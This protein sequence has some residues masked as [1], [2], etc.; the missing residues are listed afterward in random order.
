M[1]LEQIIDGCKR[2]DNNA[3]RELY[4]R[5]ANLIFGLLCRYT[6]N[7]SSAEDLL[8]DTFITIFTHIEDYRNEGAFDGWCRRIAIRTAIDHLRRE[9]R[10]DLLEID[11]LQ[12]SDAITATEPNVLDGISN[13]ELMRTINEL[14]PAFRTII[15]LRV[16]EGYDYHQIAQIIGI[17]ESTA[18]SQYRRAKTALIRKLEDINFQTKRE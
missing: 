6:N 2:S 18:R 5:Y 7:R 17:N 11:G 15:N 14:S 8:H 13:E 3:R 9:R 12:S 1:E 16:C 4:E 10:L